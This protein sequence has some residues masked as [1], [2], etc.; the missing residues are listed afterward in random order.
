MRLDRARHREILPAIRWAI[1]SNFPLAATSFFQASQR[2][3]RTPRRRPGRNVQ[4]SPKATIATI[5][6]CDKRVPRAGDSESAKNQ[7]VSAEG[8][9]DIGIGSGEKFA[10]NRVPAFAAWAVSAAPP[11]RENSQL[12]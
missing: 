1:L 2:V 6:Q 8:Q 10:T 9:A 5:E 3:A 12:L 7:G 11:A 4:V